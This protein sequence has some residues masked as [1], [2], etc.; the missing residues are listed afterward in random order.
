MFNFACGD[1]PRAYQVK[2]LKT[3]LVTPSAEVFERAGE[4]LRGGGLVAFPTE[5]VYGLGGN[6]LDPD[7]GR[8]IFA[9]KGRP[10]DNPLIV[11]ISSPEE[12]ENIAYTNEAYYKL[13]KA[14][15]PGPLTI[16]LPKKD[17]VP[18]SVTGGIKTVAVRCP[19]HEVAR[20][21]I[22]AAGVP[23][24]APS[25]NLSGS[26][27]PTTADY[28]MRDMDGRIEM[29]ID[30]G[31][32]RIG[33]ESTVVS[34]TGDICTVL[35][36]G[37]IIPR[38]IYN[39]LGEVTVAEAVKVPSAAGDNPESPGM[40]YK[41]YAPETPLVLLEGERED[42]IAFV[43]REKRKTAV[44]SYSEDAEEYKN[45]YVIDIG[46]KEDPHSQMYNLFKAL[47]DVETAE[48]DIIYANLPPDSDDFLALYNR[49]IRAC[50]GEVIN[51]LLL[52]EGE[53]LAV[54]E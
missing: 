44:L 1:H 23:V 30:G 5:T 26:P 45:A 2:K 47:R 20:D 15:M 40:K 9:A 13:A 33:V 38:E 7:A 36:P 17:I 28:V 54:Y 32:S 31:Q 18:D 49:M 27:S 21:L 11:H 14:F 50:G 29:I 24:A 46:K 22:R 51:C 42:V 37:E 52:G 48:A 8:K 12:A 34:L 19:E 43:N 41:H 53:S 25:A 3:E 35:R 39:V 6:A 16:V 10:S 4:I